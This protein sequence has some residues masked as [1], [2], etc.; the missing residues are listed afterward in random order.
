M[1]GIFDRFPKIRGAD[2]PVFTCFLGT[3]TRPEFLARDCEGNAELFSEPQPGEDYFEWLDL[4]EAAAAAGD[5]FT[6]LE[7]GAGYGKWSS[8]AAAA[9]RHIG[10]RADLGLAE[11]EPQHVAWIKQHMTDNGIT[12]YRLFAAAVA[13]T[14]GETLFVV[15]QP[16][17]ADQAMNNPR[18]WY[19]Q[20]T[21]WSQV[22]GAVVGDYFGQPLL[23]LPDGWR[24]VR[25]PQVTLSQVL[26][27][28]DF[29]DLIDFDSQGSEADAVEE[30]IEV[31][32]QKVRRLHIG[33]HGPEIED[34]LVATLSAAG[35]QCLRRFNC[36][37]EQQTQW[38]PIHFGDGVQSW[39]NPRV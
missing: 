36:L 30:A 22:E 9:A 4:L 8:R 19:G 32:G 10:K 1:T 27:H 18:E 35:W 33:T 15:G 31:L 20:A 24:A 7:I 13:G 26:D 21:Y 11:A 37:Q 16:P 6:F 3:W 5:T 2:K 34:R 38:G 12:D 29:V 17:S 28:Y 39:V 25:A 14:S 23:E